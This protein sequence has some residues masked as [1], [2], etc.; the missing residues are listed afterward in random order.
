MWVGS[1]ICIGTGAARSCCR[2]FTDA[3]G[4]ETPDAPGVP[5]LEDSAGLGEAYRDAMDAAFAAYQMVRDS[6]VEEAAESARYLLPLGTRCRALFKMD[7][8]EAFYISAS[9]GAGW[10]ATTAIGGWL[11][12]CSSGCGNRSGLGWRDLFR[13]E[14]V[15][16]S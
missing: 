15:A 2:E 9:C 1:G 4:Y 13:V 6:G 14:D 5:T 16:D 7:F 10:R 11:G 8:A 3:H 12:R